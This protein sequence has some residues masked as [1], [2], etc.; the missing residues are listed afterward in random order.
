[1]EDTGMRMDIIL[2]FKYDPWR[3]KDAIKLIQEMNGNKGIQI[4]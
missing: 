4:R 1:M 3:V 2:V